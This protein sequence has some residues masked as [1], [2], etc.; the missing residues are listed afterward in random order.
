MTR[1]NTSALYM[2]ESVCDGARYYR[3]CIDFT[4]QISPSQFTHPNARTARVLAYA[5][6]RT[7]KYFSQA[8]IVLGTVKMC[9]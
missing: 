1:T 5:D 7:A 6:T 8:V 3:V 2:G 4:W 9:S